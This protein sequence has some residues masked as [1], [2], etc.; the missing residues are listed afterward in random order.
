MIKICF[1]C[2]GNTCRSIMAERLMKKIIKEYKLSDFKIISR[3]LNANGEMITDNAKQV[4][5]KYHALAS[6]RKSIKLGKIDKETLYVTMTENQKK[7]ILSSK[8]VISYKSLIGKD[9]M[10]PFGQSIEVY[11]KTA[12]ELIDGI[13]KLINIIVNWR[14][15]KN[16]NFSK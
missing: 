7:Q 5:K 4:L 16:D 14:E 8:K 11:L 3:G 9:V 13:E 2:T 12:D 6:N 15:N 1:V 10:D